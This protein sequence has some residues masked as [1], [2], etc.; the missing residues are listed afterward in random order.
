MPDRDQL[1]TELSRTLEESNR[2]LMELHKQATEQVQRELHHLVATRKL[3]GAALTEDAYGQLL[4]ETPSIS[5]LRSIDRMVTNELDLT[6]FVR[7]LRDPNGGKGVAE[8]VRE[9]AALVDE[10]YNELTKELANGK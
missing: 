9:H 6:L 3:Q 8:F 10:L 5:N 2:K 7:A 1:I 4:L